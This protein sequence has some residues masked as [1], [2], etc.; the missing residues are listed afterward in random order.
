LSFSSPQLTL[1]LNW[2]FFQGTLTAIRDWFRD[3]KIP[4]GKPASRFGLGNKAANK[5][6]CASFSTAKITCYKKW[7]FSCLYSVTFPFDGGS[8]TL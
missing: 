6:D 7:Y 8:Y 3:Y 2:Q 5:V 4:D 1:G